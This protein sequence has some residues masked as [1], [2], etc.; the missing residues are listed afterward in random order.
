MVRK[1][2]LSPILRAPY[3]PHGRARVVRFRGP[4][5]ATRSN[6]PVPPS[7][8]AARDDAR[9]SARRSCRSRSSAGPRSGD[10]RDPRSAAPRP[11]P[12]DPSAPARGLVWGGCQQVPRAIRPVPRARR[13]AEPVAADRSEPASAPRGSAVRV[14][15]CSDPGGR[16]T[17]AG[18]RG[19]GRHP[20]SGRAAALSNTGCDVASARDP[21]SRR[22]GRRRGPPDPDSPVPARV[23][24]STAA[25]SRAT[26]LPQSRGERQPG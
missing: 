12:R 20:R 15:A 18:Q 19:R 17:G 2:T 14:D 8:A 9:W 16:R 25:G 3:R 1:R 4:V 13:C 11:G 22:N 10:R 24:Q 26:A 23:R 21:T 6:H 7:P 5:A